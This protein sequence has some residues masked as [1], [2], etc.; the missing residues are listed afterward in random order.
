[1]KKLLFGVAA[2]PFLFWNSSQAV[3]DGS[4]AEVEVYNNSR[5]YASL[6]TAL[7]GYSGYFNQHVNFI[8]DDGHV[9]EL[10]IS[11]GQQWVDT[12]LTVKG[13]ERTSGSN[14]GVPGALIGYRE[15]VDNSQHIYFII[16][17]DHIHHLHWD[18][19]HWAERT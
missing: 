2:L 3:A 10:F 1:M 14:L 7:T 12:N 15:Q 11:P 13:N 6:T 4:C 5:H 8:S 16:T 19:S 17:D 18:G 9:R